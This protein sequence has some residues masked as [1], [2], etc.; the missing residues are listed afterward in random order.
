MKKTIFLILGAVLA[1]AACEP[2]EKREDPGPVLTREQLDF[3]VTQ[4]PAGSNT[5]IL[6]NNT[7]N[8]ISYWDWGTGF[9]NKQ[10]DTIYIPFAGT[11]VVKFTAFYKGG[12]VTDSTTFTI[13]SN[14]DA[15]FDQDPAWKGLTGGGAGKTWVWAT[16]HPSG[17]VLGN[18][19]N[20]AVAPQWWQVRPFGSDAWVTNMMNDE[21]YMDLQGAANFELRKG[22]GSVIKGFFNI[23]EPVTIEGVTYSTMEVLGGPTWPWPSAKR[24]TITK[25]NENELSIHPFDAFD[26][27]VY[28]QKGFSY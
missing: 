2:T 13:T 15:F 18:G 11:F 14:D 9:S 8:T 16:D 3:S 24:Y 28:K 27:A 25:L 7:K 6:E 1:F 26:V 5:I 21:V 12:T 22:N 19:P 10:R 23:T 20:N 4:D 17:F